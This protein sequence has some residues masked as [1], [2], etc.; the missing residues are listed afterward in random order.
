MKRDEYLADE[1]VAKF[2]NWAGQLVTGER[3]LKHQW[4]SRGTRFRRATLYEALLQ[5]RW[6]DNSKGIDF[7]MT[8]QRLQQFRDTFQ[9]IGRVDSQAKQERF[10]ANVER[11]MEWGGISRPPDGLNDWRRMH[12]EK[13][14]S[15]TEEIRAKLNPQAA[16]TADLGEFRYMGAGLS[17]VYSLLVEGFPIYDSWVAC[18]LGCMVRIYCKEQGLG[19]IPDLLRFRMPPSRRPKN[20]IYHWCGYPRMNNNPVGYAQDNLKAAWLLQEMVRDPGMF[21]CVPGVAPVDA[22]Q[23]AL[24]MVGYAQL[25]DTAILPADGR[26]SEGSREI[27]EVQAEEDYGTVSGNSH[28]NARPDEDSRTDNDSADHDGE[29]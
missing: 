28:G 5:Y 23:S 1:H 8:A 20:E 19:R 2:T 13:L 9:D 12:P 14:Q 15:L 17:K 22:L 21:G 16:D 10:I 24:F 4:N 27:A 26:G 25:S 7:R 11:I 29:Q 3:R 6:P 18:A